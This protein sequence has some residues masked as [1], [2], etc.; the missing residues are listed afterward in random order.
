MRGLHVRE[1]NYP[2]RII[3]WISATKCFSR[4]RD[5]VP[6]A[7]AFRPFNVA[8]SRRF[9]SEKIAVTVRVI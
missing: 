3:R 6:H 4:C 2:D 8:T 5:A 9:F 7:Y 1:D